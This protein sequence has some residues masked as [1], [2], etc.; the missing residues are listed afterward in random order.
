MKSKYFIV[1]GRPELEGGVW[2]DVAQWTYLSIVISFDEPMR[3]GY[4]NR[5]QIY[6]VRRGIDVQFQIFRNVGSDTGGQQFLVAA[7]FPYTTR[8]NDGFENTVNFICMVVLS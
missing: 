8:L 4:L 6:S 2:T 1:Y 7:E 3:R 5:I